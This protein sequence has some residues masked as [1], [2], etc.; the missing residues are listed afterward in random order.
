MADCTRRV[1]FLSTV[2]KNKLVGRVVS[3]C[4]AR[5]KILSSNAYRVMMQSSS[6][7]TF[8]QE[9]QQARTHSYRQSHATAA[10][11]VRASHSFTWTT[12]RSSRVDLHQD[13]PP[14]MHHG[15]LVQ[16]NKRPCEMESCAAHN[17][18]NRTPHS[19]GFF[20]S[21]RNHGRLVIYWP[22]LYLQPSPM[23]C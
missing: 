23:I 12:A 17:P 19:P 6:H 20:I 10:A 7:H 1:A 15:S 22:Q 11:C 13:P 8:Y 14:T 16:S 4:R 2:L 18:P 9:H 5:G 3:A 21:L